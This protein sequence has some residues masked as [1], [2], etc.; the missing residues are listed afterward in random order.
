MKLTV[1]T[2]AIGGLIVLAA[3]PLVMAYA[4]ESLSEQAMYYL[5]NM[6][7]AGRDR[8]TKS[9]NNSLLRTKMY[10]R[11]RCTSLL[12]RDTRPLRRRRC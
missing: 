1:I 6:P 11:F 12:K 4:R 5:R 10:R 9:E 2:G 7:R 3:M 8:R